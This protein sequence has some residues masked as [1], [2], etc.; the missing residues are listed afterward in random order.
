[1]AARE[2]RYL[3]LSEKFLINFPDAPWKVLFKSMYS[4]HTAW[5]GYMLVCNP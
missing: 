1:M 2:K 4:E 3:V 5:G